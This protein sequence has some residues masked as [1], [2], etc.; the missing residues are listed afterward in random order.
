MLASGEDT[1]HE[2]VEETLFHVCQRA[3]PFLHGLG[4]VTALRKEKKK[5]KKKNEEEKDKHIR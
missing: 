5:R 2:K 3:P 4:N 1:G